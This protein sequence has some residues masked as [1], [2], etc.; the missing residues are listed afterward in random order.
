[1]S[2][3]LGVPRVLGAKLSTQEVAGA[4][5][6]LPAG[7]PK[8]PDN[9]VALVILQVQPIPDAT[10]V[11]L[12]D[13]LGHAADAAW[14]RLGQALQHLLQTISLALIAPWAP[15]I[16]PN[17]R[18]AHRRNIGVSV[19]LC[20]LTTSIPRVEHDVT[21]KI[22]KH[23]VL[24]ESGKRPVPEGAVVD[25]HHLAKLLEVPVAGRVRHLSR[26]SIPILLHVVVSL[27][28]ERSNR[29]LLEKAI[30]SAT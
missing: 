10:Q 3:E 30:N 18:G 11:G 27:A 5:H 4:A 6:E 15:L 1:M 23:Q 19:H 7:E 2:L 9:T 17:D 29:A 26:L 25:V 8:S 16:P 21:R 28:E 12:H 13:W 22:A 24:L 14:R 20:V